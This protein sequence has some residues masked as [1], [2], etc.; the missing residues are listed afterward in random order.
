MNDAIDKILSSRQTT[1][2]IVA[3]RISTIARA[4]RIVVLEGLS[5]TFV[6]RILCLTELMSRI[7]WEDHGVWDVPSTGEWPIAISVY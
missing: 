1:C 6:L 4:E 5:A 3:H 2:L 7:R